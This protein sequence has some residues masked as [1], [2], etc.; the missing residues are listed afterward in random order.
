MSVDEGS[1]LSPQSRRRD[2]RRRENVEGGRQTRHEVRVSPE[3]EGIL[4]RLA[5]AQQVTI[6]RLLVESALASEMVETT[7]ERKQA[8][9]ELFAMH[10]LLAGIAN[11]VNQ[12]AKATNATREVQPATV[13]TLAKV[14][15][16]A[17]RIDQAI[18]ALT[19]RA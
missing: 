17:D 19:I 8:M 4:L 13:Q 2:R 15:E 1:D 16:V 12:I 5:L 3:E 14:R 18:D 7:T 11:N 6:P 9:A 10:R